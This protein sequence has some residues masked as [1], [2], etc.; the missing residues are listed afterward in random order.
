[1]GGTLRTCKEKFYGGV[2]D[3]LRSWVTAAFEDG[4][5]VRFVREGPTREEEGELAMKKSPRKSPVKAG[6]KEKPP[7]LD[8]PKLDL[9]VGVSNDDDDGWLG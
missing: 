9:N 3:G 6:A 1:M 4:W 5:D 8:V 2:H 7:V